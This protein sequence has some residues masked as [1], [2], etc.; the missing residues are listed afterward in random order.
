MTFHS[1]WQ[2]ARPRR[3]NMRFIGRFMT[4][5]GLVSSLFDVLTFALLLGVFHASV[6]EFRTGWFVESLL[7]ELSV[8]L[9]VRTRRPFYRSKPGRLLTLAS[10]AVFLLTLAL[11]YLPGIGVFGF[12]PLPAPLFFGV[13]AINL[14]YVW[15]TELTKWRFYRKDEETSPAL[16]AR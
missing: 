3:W 11:P 15:A 1:T 7:T 5:F 4:V 16:L 13:L 14:L 10:L 12:V 8:A 6:E 2:F 9:V